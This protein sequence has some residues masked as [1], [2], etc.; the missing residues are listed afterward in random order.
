MKRKTSLILFL[1]TTLA[2]AA[3]GGTAGTPGSTGSAGPAAQAG[4]ASNLKPSDAVGDVPLNEEARNLLPVSIRDSGVLKIGGE[5]QLPPYLYKEGD[6]IVGLEADFMVALGKSLGLSPQVENTKFASMVTG[7]TSNRIDVAMSDFSDTLERQKQV[8]FVDYT[9]AGQVLM[10]QDGNPK[11]IKSLA[12]LCGKSTG[13]P[14]G[15]LS[16][17]IA[18]EQSDK[19][20]AEGKEPVRVDQFPSGSD[21][22]LA[23]QNKRIDSI[24]FDVALAKQLEKEQPDKVEAVGDLFGLGYHGA[25]VRISDADLQKALKAA[26]EGL[27]KDGTYDRIMK[28]WDLESMAMDSVEINATK[29]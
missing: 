2:L 21:A 13:G 7:L 22:T 29:S 17:K 25:A 23:L 14:T 15:S 10:V 16:V 27:Q 5:T 19:C 28:Q 3:C 6:K 24:A 4:A 8:T 12:D 1:S 11:G 20:V 9:R 26:F 18:Q